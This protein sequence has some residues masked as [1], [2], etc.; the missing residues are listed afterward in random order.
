MAEQNNKIKFVI[1]NTDLKKAVSTLDGKIN[2]ELDKKYR[3]KFKTTLKKIFSDLNSLT[4]E[5]LS[6]ENLNK[7]VSDAV[8]TLSNMIVPG[9]GDALV[10]AIGVAINF[11][12]GLFRDDKIIGYEK[13]K[14]VIEDINNELEKRN[15]LLEIAKMLNSSILDTTK[16]QLEYQKTSAELLAQSLG[17]EGDIGELNIEDVVSRYEELM[18][19]IDGYK[20]KANEL[21]T[22]IA[23][24]NVF[25]DIWEWITS[26]FGGSKE[27]ELQNIEVRIEA[28]EL[29]AEQYKE[30]AELLEKIAILKKQQI[31]E[32]YKEME[33]NAK[34][35]DNEAKTYEA[36]IQYYRE[37]LRRSEE[38]GLSRL[39]ILEIENKLKETIEE[40]F[41]YIVGMYD[42][43]QELIIKKAKLGGA[44]EEELNQLRLQAIENLIRT[45]EM[46]IEELGYTLDRE[47]ELIDLELERLAIQKELNNELGMQG[48][49]YDKNVRSIL[50][51]VIEARKLGN[52]FSEQEAIY[53]AMISLLSQGFSLSQA[54][55]ILGTDFDESDFAGYY[56]GY[57]EED[58]PEFNKLA[59]KLKDIQSLETDD[60]ARALPGTMASMNNLISEE[61]TEIRKQ[62]N[63]LIT[64]NGLLQSIDRGV[65]AGN[66]STSHSTYH[67][68]NSAS[69]GGITPSQWHRFLKQMNK[70]NRW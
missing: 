25:Q 5:G 34:L 36:R 16:E 4:K 8:T 28:L 2:Y 22:D 23:D 43:E 51:A 38:L 65:N 39:E 7:F 30:L 42:K 26:I 1:D 9:I 29:E 52:V 14:L 40:R 27:D 20:E 31:E 68:N 48:M 18:S 56:E 47:T 46:E 41:D 10:N 35:N 53:N 69:G 70:Q 12:K 67:Y 37:L 66:N 44:S 45:K 59:K 32:T 19:L 21:R 15:S 13:Q 60:F 50:R 64:Q 63:L 24:D 57:S 11:L 6:K 49:L 33:L 58:L 61:L 55:D 17:F 62:N 54:N 3:E